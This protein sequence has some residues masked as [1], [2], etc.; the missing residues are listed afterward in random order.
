MSDTLANDLH[1]TQE[2]EKLWDMIK[3]M[4]FGMFTHRH[5]GSG[6]LHSIPLTTQNK[7]VDED[8]A[9][10]FFISRTSEAAQCIASE[11]QVNVSYA[12]LSAD[13]YVS[14]SGKAQIS[15]D[16]AKKEALFTPMAK[17]WFPGGFN[18]P[19]MA[20]LKVD[21]SHAEYWDVKESKMTQLFKMAKA[22]VTGD[23]PSGM[24]EH[25]ELKLG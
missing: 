6:L 9:L 18:D 17:A 4:R 20:L 23:R 13:S 11:P 7:A 3:E 22:A 1:P 21:I 5:P 2:H 8:S 12:D 19:T 14:V 25:R 15:E 16:L 24:G 10:Y